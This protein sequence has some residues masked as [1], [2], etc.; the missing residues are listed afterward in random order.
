MAFYNTTDESGPALEASRCKGRKQ[1]SAVL[2]YYLQHPNNFVSPSQLFKAFEHK[3]WPI[4][5][6]RRAVTDLTRDGL[7]V[8]TPKTVMGIY[9]KK[10]H[11][12][13]L[14]PAYF[15]ETLFNE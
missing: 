11:C 6:I 14:K 8:K 12:W 10:E 1:E 2:G 15:Q 4:T 7:L 13:K 9:G 5:S 3:N